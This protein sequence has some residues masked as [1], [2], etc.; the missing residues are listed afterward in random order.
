M[1]QGVVKTLLFDWTKLTSSNDELRDWQTLS[2]LMSIEMSLL[3]VSARR[4]F[5]PLL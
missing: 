2:L 1:L 4:L 3:N 5:A